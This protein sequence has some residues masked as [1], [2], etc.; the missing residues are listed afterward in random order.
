MWT[1]YDFREER[2]VNT[3]RRWLNGLPP[4]AAAKINTR[5]LYMMA[6]SVWP[7]QYVSFLVGWPGLVEIRVVH[8]GVQYRPLGFYGPARWEFTIVLGAVEKGSI[9]TRDLETA[10]VNRKLVIATGR[11]RICEHEFDTTANA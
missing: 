11:S 6:R 8:G 5:L 3:I 7:E 9:P 4:K 1:F 2:G 10:D